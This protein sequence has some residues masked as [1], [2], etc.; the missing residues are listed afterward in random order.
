[1]SLGDL[2]VM[3]NITFKELH[4]III[5]KKSIKVFLFLLLIIIIKFF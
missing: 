2:N 3:N 4:K 1:M 5:K